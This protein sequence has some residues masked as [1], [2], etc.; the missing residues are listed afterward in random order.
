MSIETR[1]R[2]VNSNTETI[3]PSPLPPIHQPETL[4]TDVDQEVLNQHYKYTVE[5]FRHDLNCAI[6]GEPNAKIVLQ[7]IT[8][9]AA[10]IDNTPAP[11]DFFNRILRNHD[12]QF[13]Y[14]EGLFPISDK[15]THEINSGTK[16]IIQEVYKIQDIKARNR[17]RDL[18]D[19]ARSEYIKKMTP[20]EYGKYNG[21]TNSNFKYKQTT[22]SHLSDL[23]P[24]L[25][26]NLV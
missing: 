15:E 3:N 9:T 20:V 14:Q 22:S 12:G 16:Q 4:L 25:K 2:F 6:N 10:S 26:R 23:D 1:A 11:S 21:V 5:D 24:S 17:I 8:R 7:Q 18:I 19:R 13:V